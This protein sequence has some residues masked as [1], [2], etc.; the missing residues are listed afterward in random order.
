MTDFARGLHVTGRADP[1]RVVAWLHGA[2]VVARVPKPA[3]RAWEV[4]AMAGWLAEKNRVAI[5]A[6]RGQA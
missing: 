1:A 6:Y 2:G 5:T 3:R 4:I